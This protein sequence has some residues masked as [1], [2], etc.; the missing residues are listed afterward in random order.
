LKNEPARFSIGIRHS[1]IRAR[2]QG[3]W[4]AEC[5]SAAVLLTVSPV[6]SPGKGLPI[7]P[8]GFIGRQPD[9]QAGRGGGV[10]LT[11]PRDRVFEVP[12]ASSTAGSW[13]WEGSSP[14]N[15]WPCPPTAYPAQPAG[16]V[17]PAGRRLDRPLARPC[18][19]P[20]ITHGHAAHAGPG[21]ERPI[22]RD[23]RPKACCRHGWARRSALT[24][25]DSRPELK[26]G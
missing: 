4:P 21:S 5:V 17:L 19:G 15:A 8:G 12:G 3:R 1:I 25:M 18:P 20:L 11:T 9:M 16:A 23:Q 22:G 6:Q 24:A 2:G 26:A 14:V 10:A 7:V 13:L